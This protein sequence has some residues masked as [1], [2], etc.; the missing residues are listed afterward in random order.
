MEQVAPD[1]CESNFGTAYETYKDAVRK[2]SRIRLQNVKDYL[3][4]RD[5]IQVESKPRGS[6][7][8]ASPGVKFEFEIDIMDMLAR[9][10]VGIRYGMVAIDILTKIAEVIPIENRQPTE[11]T[12]ASKLIV[13]SMGKPKQLYSD[14]ESSFRAK[15]FFRCMNENDVKH[16]QTSTHAPSAERFIRTFKDNSYRRLYGFKQD[17]REWV[18]HVSSILTKYNNTEHNTT[19]TKPSD[20]VKTR[21]PFMGEFAFAKQC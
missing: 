14:E 15:V 11:L 6:N 7:S 17:K 5:D 13:R 3:V 1:V 4:K 10:G 8:F 19:K 21:K 9:D 16:I 12:A 18:K 20:A 2:D